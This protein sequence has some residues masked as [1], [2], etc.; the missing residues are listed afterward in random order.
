MLPKSKELPYLCAVKI[1]TTMPILAAPH[2]QPPFPFRN[3]HVNTIYPAVFRKV[4]DVNYERERIHTPDGDFLDL[5]WSLLGADTLLIAVHGL[6]GNADRA[7]MRGMVRRFNL[8]GWDV[9]ALN[10]RGC[11]GE[12]NQQLRAYHMGATDDLQTV[13]SHVEGLDRYRR[14]A[15]LGFSLGGNVVMRYLGEKGAQVPKLIQRAAVFSVPCHLLTASANFNLLKNRVY[16]KRFLKTLN[17]KMHDKALRFPDEYQIRIA[18]PRNFDEFDEVFTAPVHGYQGAVDY[19]T[20]AGSRDVLHQ[21]SIPSL[22]VN[23]QDDTFLSE[24]CFPR[25]LAQNSSLFHLMSPRFGGHCGFY[26]PGRH[27]IYWSE[28]QAFRFIAGS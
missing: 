21:I 7:Y 1:E 10:M 13:I 22:M 27:N 25:E 11:S 19:W 14:V 17:E 5:D 3:A 12:P 26:T 18:R 9:L 15:L 6:E 23:A 16:L 2:Y 20:R 8:G 28:E 24:E 4:S